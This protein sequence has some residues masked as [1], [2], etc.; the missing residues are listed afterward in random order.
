MLLNDTEKFVSNLQELMH[1]EPSEDD[2]KQ[3]VRCLLDYL[4]ASLAG[5]KLQKRKLV[6]S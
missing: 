6:K 3:V 5:I 2:C 4:G 1:I